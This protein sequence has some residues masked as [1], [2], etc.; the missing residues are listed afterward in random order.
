MQPDS[1]TAADI[2]GLT[3]LLQFI[4]DWIDT[5]EAELTPSFNRLVDNPGIE[6]HYLRHDLRRYAALLGGTTDEPLLEP[7][8]I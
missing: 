6:I 2:T 8:Q 1:L 3:E 5:G 7:G 4:I